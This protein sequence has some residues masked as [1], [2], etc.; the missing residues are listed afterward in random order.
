MRFPCRPVRLDFVESAPLRFVKEVEIDAPPEAV[1]NILADEDAWPRF[2]R[3]VM[4]AKWT[5]PEPPGV[6]STRTLV[7]KGMTVKEHFIAWEP[8]KRFTFCLLEATVPLA[9]AL[10]EDYRLEARG[11]GKCRLTYIMACEPSLLLN[12]MGPVGKRLLGDLCNR[13]TLGLADFVKDGGGSK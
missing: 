5:S 3:D 13:V 7:L 9:R 6:G 12:L 4:T 1:F 11:S 2:L 10:C 8:G